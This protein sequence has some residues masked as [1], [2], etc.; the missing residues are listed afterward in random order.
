MNVTTYE[1]ENRKLHSKCY[2][3]KISTE[4]KE[5]AEVLIHTKITENNHVIT[6]FQYADLLEEILSKENMN[7]AYKKVKSNKGA[8]GVDKMSVDELLTYLKN[9]S[10]ILIQ[11]IRE[12]KY[13]PNPVRRVEIPKEENDT[14]LIKLL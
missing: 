9:N 12:G 1:N 11:Q 2:Q 8:G 10:K 6:E 7:R 3:Q 5:Y 13:K 14:S 4:S